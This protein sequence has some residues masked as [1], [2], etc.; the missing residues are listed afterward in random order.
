MGAHRAESTES[1]SG[2]LDPKWYEHTTVNEGV[3]L[4]EVDMMFGLLNGA[5][6]NSFLQ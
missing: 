4:A 2:V 6:P 3:A 1:A 5:F